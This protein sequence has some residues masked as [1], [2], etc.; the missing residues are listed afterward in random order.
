MTWQEIN[1]ILQIIKQ[2]DITKNAP[3]NV[4][5]WGTTESN[6]YFW[7]GLLITALPPEI[8]SW[9]TVK[10]PPPLPNPLCIEPIIVVEPV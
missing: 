5:L 10:C 2:I 6:S 1:E 9:T 8:P 4:M 7:G 3:R